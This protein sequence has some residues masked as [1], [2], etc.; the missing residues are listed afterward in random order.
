MAGQPAGG[1]PLQATAAGRDAFYRT[2]LGVR[3]TAA[4][5]HLNLALNLRLPDHHHH[6][7]A[8]HHHHTDAQGVI[9]SAFLWG[10]MATQLLGG[11][12]ADK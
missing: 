11:A 5:P 2:C 12:L 4:A 7:D 10:Y 3:G 6:T 9:Q 1:R 8:H